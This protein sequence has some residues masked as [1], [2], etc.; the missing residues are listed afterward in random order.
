MKVETSAGTYFIDWR[1][2]LNAGNSKAVTTC[3]IKNDKIEVIATNQAFCSTKDNFCK[4]K[5]RK[6]GENRIREADC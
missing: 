1:H 6:N 2:D 4:E 5:G 3:F